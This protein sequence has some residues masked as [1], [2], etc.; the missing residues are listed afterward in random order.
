MSHILSTRE[1]DKDGI[2]LD[3]VTSEEAAEKVTRYL[4][5]R[6]DTNDEQVLLASHMDI[7]SIRIVS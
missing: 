3:T 6:I 4:E 5:A 1:V 2:V 7:H